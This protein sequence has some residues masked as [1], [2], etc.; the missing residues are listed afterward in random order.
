MWYLRILGCTGTPFRVE[1]FTLWQFCCFSE[2]SMR[3]K[4]VH[5]G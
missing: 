4:E 5:A 2:V 1:L 3:A